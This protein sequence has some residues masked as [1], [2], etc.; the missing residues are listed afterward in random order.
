V[1]DTG[2]PVSD[3]RPLLAFGP[4]ET[5]SIPPREGPQPFR[6]VR[7]PG[8]GRQGERLTPQFQELQQ[9]LVAENAQL[10]E[11][12]E[13]PDPELVAVFDLAG[14]VDRFLRACE[15]IDGLE[16]LADLQEDQVAADD[17]FYYEDQD[18]VSD[19]GVPQSLYM[20]MSN[21]EAVRELVRLFELWQ[22]DPS[23]TFARGLNPLKQVFELLRAIRRWGPEDRI[24]ETGLLEDWEDTVSTIGSSGVAR[25][26]VEL[27]YRSDP[28][29]RAA[30]EAA[31]VQLIDTAGGQVVRTS[32]IPDIQFH[33]LLADIPYDQVRA[34]LADGPDAIELLTAES[35]MF[36]TPARPM[37]L[38][39]PRPTAFGL[40][41]LSTEL[42]EGPPRIALLDGLPFANHVSLQGRLIIDDPDG[43]A[44]SYGS[45][46]QSHGTAMA[47]LIAHGDLTTPGPTVGS[48]LYVRPILQPHPWVDDVELVVPDE[49]LVDLIHRS[50]RRIFEGDGQ[51]P[52]AAPSV[53][54]VNLSIGDPARMFIRRLSPLAKLLDWLAHKYNI[55]IVVSA[56]NHTASPAVP[57]AAIGDSAQLHEAAARS[58]H[59]ELRKRRL[60]SPAEAVNVLTVGAQH[61]DSAEVTVPDT[62]IDAFES[63]GPA[64]YSATGFGF[65][66][67]V[68][69]DVLLPGGRELF[70]RPVPGPDASTLQSARVEAT[71]PGIRVAAPGLAGEVDGSVYTCGSSNAAALAT[72]TIDQIYEVLNGLSTETGEFDFPDPQYHPVLAK[73]LLV[74][75]ARWGDIGATLRDQLGLS[76]QRR[77]RDLTQM[78]GYGPVD[79]TRVTSAERVRPVLLG[80]GSIMKDKRQTFRFP[81]PVGLST[82]AEWRR[83]T[84]TLAW[85]SQVNTRSQKH[86]MARLAVEVPRST[87]AVEPIEADHQ[88]VL[89]GTVQH[90]VLDGQ[91]VVGFVSGSA[92]EI[93]VD[94]RVDAGTLSAPIRYGLVASLEVAPAVQVDLHAQVRQGI[95]EQVQERVRQQ[96]A[97]R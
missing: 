20:V 69:P 36:V 61:A 87:L 65:R 92:M 31:V 94:C 54:V 79:L 66:R 43:R 60:L 15:G 68:K 52:A 29:R 9:A 21:A 28:G 48:P 84:V 55:V 8:T 89:K 46:Q 41:D 64:G 5:T 11:T 62:V 71:G 45:G 85:I 24:R 17:D 6:R 80:A 90:Q 30:V 58:Y 47:G 82:T 37:A 23:V 3:S 63:N 74:H 76:A 86:R 12:S 44:A 14:T 2:S 38:P 26:E 7:A 77:R 97:V 25:V 13:A 27:W 96:V 75:A 53:R 51:Q 78:L 95:R 34:V 4:P 72:R 56:G 35:V 81:L 19:D 16:F 22:Q 49:I 10:A 40:A 18:D 93:S 88:A 73:A 32:A 1:A 83:L 70:L 39:A 67:S 33:G 42:P 59:A 50:F 57:T 91:A